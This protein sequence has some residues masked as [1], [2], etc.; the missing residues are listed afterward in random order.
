MKRIYTPGLL[1]VFSMILFFACSSAEEEKDSTKMEAPKAE[2]EIENTV[3]EDSVFT[4][5]DKMPV[6][7]GG[8]SELLKHIFNNVVYPEGAKKAGTEGR[9]I[10]RFCVNND[11]KINRVSI[12]KGASPE[13]DAEAV[14]VISNLPPFESPGYKDGKAVSVWYVV[15]ISF[16]LK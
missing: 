16:R 13:L 15:P 6:F 1:A 10:V 3:L 11:G 8:E 12:L 4:E 2:Q 7:A 9:S 5:V 14:R